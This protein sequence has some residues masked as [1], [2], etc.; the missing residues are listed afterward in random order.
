MSAPPKPRVTGH[1]LI[2]VLAALV[3]I[4]IAL[5]GFLYSQQQGNH[6]NRGARAHA[7]VVSALN[8]MAA[9]IAMNPDAVDA[10][11]T[12]FG[13]SPSPSTCENQPCDTAAFARHQVSR[14]KCRFSD[15]S[16]A[17]ACS[18]APAAQIDG[19]GQVQRHGDAVDIAVRWRIGAEEFSLNSSV[20]YFGASP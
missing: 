4:N 14:W 13:A 18:D 1:S 19:D 15:W 12:T 17:A 20:P 9:A 5:L 8:D 16:N 11:A 6:R 10:Y 3:I 7:F 2:E